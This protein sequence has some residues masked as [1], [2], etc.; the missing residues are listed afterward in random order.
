MY[1]LSYYEQLE[2]IKKDVFKACN[3][4]C[5]ELARTA[6]DDLSTS[7]TSILK[8][9]YDTYDPEYY[10]RTFNLYNML[11]KKPVKMRNGSKNTSNKYTATI[12]ADANG[13]NDC[14]EDPR[15]EVYDLV[16]NNAIRGKREIQYPNRNG[17]VWSPKFSDAYANNYNAATPHELMILYMNNWGDVSKNKK[18]YDILNKYRSSK[19]ITFY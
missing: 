2:L 15:S 8:D 12:F 6:R 1:R 5:G 3:K 14:Y 4:I 7:M 18:V 11:I 13:M 19:V 9:Y 17:W 16:W 10:S